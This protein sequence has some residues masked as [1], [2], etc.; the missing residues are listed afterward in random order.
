MLSSK[1]EIS[2]LERFIKKIEALHS[3]TSVGFCSARLSLLLHLFYLSCHLK[4]TSSSHVG[5]KPNRNQ[6]NFLIIV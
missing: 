3:V 4:I 2:Q 1:T 6:E 5:K